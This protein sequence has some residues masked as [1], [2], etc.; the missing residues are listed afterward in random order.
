[1]RSSSLSSHTIEVQSCTTFRA[2]EQSRRWRNH[3]LKYKCKVGY[4][5]GGGG[6]DSHIKIQMQDKILPGEPPVRTPEVTL[7][8]L[9]QSDKITFDC[10]NFAKR[11]ACQ[12]NRTLWLAN[13]CWELDNCLT[14]QCFPGK[15]ALKSLT[16]DRIWNRYICL[17]MSRVRLQHT[18]RFSRTKDKANCT[19]CSLIG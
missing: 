1:M 8:R 14:T 3:Y 17:T 16:Y 18:R 7:L 11:W 19:M 13:L 6:A 5:G 12:L 2:E 15:L 4:F 9:T 10:H